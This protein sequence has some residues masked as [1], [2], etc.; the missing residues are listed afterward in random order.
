[1]LLTDRERTLFENKILKAE[2]GCWLWTAAIKGNGYGN[3]GLRGKT[4]TAHRVA[5]LLYKGEIPEDK[6]V[7]HSC[8][9][10]CCVNPEH[11]LL[12]TYKDNSQDMVRHGRVATHWSKTSPEKIKKGDKHWNAKLTKAKALKAIAMYSS[13]K[14]SQREIGRRL[15][16]HYASINDLVLGKTWKCLLGD[17]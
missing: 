12:G 1:M 15:G 11:L 3:F 10:R 17:K 13:G 6:I 2:D 4:K 14:Y 5:F 9:V 16:V 8:D 7:R